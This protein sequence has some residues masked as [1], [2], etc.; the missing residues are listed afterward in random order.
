MANRFLLAISIICLAATISNGWVAGTLGGTVKDPKGAIIVGA[1]VRAIAA[2]TGEIRTAVTDQQGRFK[3]DGLAPGTY[4]IEIDSSGF[5]LSQ[6]VNVQVQEGRSVQ[7]DI[8]M[9]VAG[10]K[11]ELSVE[12]KGTL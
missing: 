2:T 3:I 11:E 12:G 10:V 6:P 8:T 4:K 9:E 7:V 5:K 1:Q